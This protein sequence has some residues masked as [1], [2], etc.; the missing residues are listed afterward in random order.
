MNRLLEICRFFVISFEFLTM[1]LVGLVLLVR[2]EWFVFIGTQF[3]QNNDAWKYLSYIPI[4]LVGTSVTLAKGILKPFDS[5]SNKEL[6]EWEYYWKLKD[7]VL[8]SIL[9]SAGCA[10]GSLSLWVFSDKL[11]ESIIGAIFVAS[12]SVALIVTY[13][14]LLAS[15]RIRE[16]MEP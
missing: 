9:L 3:K 15:F 4:F 16:I 8:A 5:R 2:P 1:L 7:R 14:Q 12:I 10:I 13:N 6:Y 11:T